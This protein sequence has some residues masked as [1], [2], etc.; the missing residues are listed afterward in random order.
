[1]E[2][3]RGV[4][5]HVAGA[6]GS[7]PR[8]R[9]LRHAAARGTLCAVH[10]C[11]EEGVHECACACVRGCVCGSAGG[12][13]G[14]KVQL[15]ESSVAGVASVLPAFVRQV[16]ASAVRRGCAL[17]ARV[18]RRLTRCACRQMAVSLREAGPYSWLSMGAAALLARC[19]C[20]C[21]RARRSMSPRTSPRLR[22]HPAAARRCSAW[23][24]GQCC[25]I[26]HTRMHACMH[27]FIHAHTH[28]HTHTAD[29]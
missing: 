26:R 13:P 27:A 4:G 14:P 24:N 7:A 28:T 23:A 11:V 10:A 22:V 3:G 25:G 20:A 21:S 8:M 16:R 12:M 17:R 5:G 18:G 2:S 29:E 6:A 9:L 19:S 1:M 15:T